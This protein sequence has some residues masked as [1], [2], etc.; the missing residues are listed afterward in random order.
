MGQNLNLKAWLVIGTIVTTTVF[1]SHTILAYTLDVNNPLTTAE[2]KP[3]NDLD[4][5]QQG[6]SAVAAGNLTQA[7]VNFDRAIELDPQYI[8]AYIER[9]NTS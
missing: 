3:T 4:P 2:I 6:L 5:Y 1:Q 7:I 8:Q 9:G